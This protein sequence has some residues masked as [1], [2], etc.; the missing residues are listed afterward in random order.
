MTT[1]TDTNKVQYSI[2]CNA[3]NSYASFNSTT[4]ITGGF[5]KCFP[6]CDNFSACAGFTFVGSDG[7]MCYLKSNLPDDGYST[8]AGGNYVTVALV[9]RNA[10]V[11]P[12]TDALPTESPNS[13]TNSKAVPIG[14]VVGGVVG[15]ILILIVLALV[16]FFYMRRRRRRR[17][18][19]DSATQR[20]KSSP[21]AALGGKYRQCPCMI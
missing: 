7:G 17:E 2:R 20:P 18:E 6:A 3:D 8:T 19:V 9:D 1:Y 15:G 5:S 4:I 16:I 12:P 10:Q 11:V 13:S 21:F 14:V